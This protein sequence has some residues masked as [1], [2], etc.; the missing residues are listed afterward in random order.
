MVRCGNWPVGVC[1]WSLRTDVAGVAEAMSRLSLEYVHLAVRPA[2]LEKGKDYLKAVQNQNWTISSTMIDFPQEDY[3]TLESIKRTGG[4]VPDEHWEQNRELFLGAVEIAAELGVE[5]LSMHAG[6]ID[7]TEPGYAKKFYHRIRYLADAAAH[8]RIILLLE[9]GQESANELR[10]FLQ[11]LSHPA[12]GVNFDPANMIL[13][14]KGDPVEA[15]RILAP[16]IKHIHIKDAI[17][18]R[19]AGTWGTEAPWGEGQV[20][21]DAF[22]KA[23]AEIRFEGTLAVERESG[24]DRFGDIKLAIERLSSFKEKTG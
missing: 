15:V 4:I 20:G 7:L 21:A 17:R 14:D 2:L 6:F 10:Q 1:S 24:S 23:L 16:W 19:Q 5:F 12:V 9:T 22:L 18:T 13:Y 8:K 11:E 3:S